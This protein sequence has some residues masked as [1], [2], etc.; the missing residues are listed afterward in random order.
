MTTTGVGILLIVLCVLLW[1]IMAALHRHTVQLEALKSQMQELLKA[2]EM[3]PNA[4]AAD[5]DPPA[6]SDRMEASSTHVPAKS[7]AVI[8]TRQ[9]VL[10]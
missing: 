3:D 6:S 9:S 1:A 4:S 5:A 10:K 8:A 7:A 2:R